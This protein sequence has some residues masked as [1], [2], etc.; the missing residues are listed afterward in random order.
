[1]PPDAVLLI[2]TGTIRRVSSDKCKKHEELG[3]APDYRCLCRVLAAA[4]PMHSGKVMQV[5]V[6][7]E[8]RGR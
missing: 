5:T 7:R 4:K 2:V 1:M 8:A 3:R 6:A